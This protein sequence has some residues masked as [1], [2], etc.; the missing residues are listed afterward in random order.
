MST[1][2]SR[3]PVVFNVD[4]DATVRELVADVLGDLG[5]EAVEFDRVSDAFRQLVRG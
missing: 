5:L 3:R 2:Q 1:E 4:P